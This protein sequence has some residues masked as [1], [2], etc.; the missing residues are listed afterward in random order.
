MR[1]TNQEKETERKS[2]RRWRRNPG[3]IVLKRRRSNSVL[4][5][6]HLIFKSVDD[7]IMKLF[8]SRLLD[9][10]SFIEAFGEHGFSLVAKTTRRR[11]MATEADEGEGNNPITSTAKKPRVWKQGIR[12][13]NAKERKRFGVVVYLADEK[14]IIQFCSV[15]AYVLFAYLT[16]GGVK[17]AS[18]NWSCISVQIFD[19]CC[20]G[21]VILN[22]RVRARYSFKFCMFFIMEVQYSGT[23][24]LYFICSI[25]VP[26]FNC[27]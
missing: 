24:F 2:W 20:V 27:E 13:I 17:I 12:S 21:F 7:L 18:V 25:R 14:Q 4:I 16:N 8:S 26:V 5:L 19:K 15:F 6:H 3:N 23:G 10:N 11:K 1:W 22:F 9:A